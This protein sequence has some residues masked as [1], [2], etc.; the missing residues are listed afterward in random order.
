MKL[1]L[2]ELGLQK[3]YHMTSVMHDPDDSQWW[4]RAIDAKFHGKGAF[5]QKEFDQLLGDC[6]V[7]CPMRWA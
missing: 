6:Q 1:A 5:G 2:E 7:S 3:C 4:I